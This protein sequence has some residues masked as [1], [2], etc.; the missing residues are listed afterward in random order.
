MAVGEEL[1]MRKVDFLVE[2]VLLGEEKGRGL[3]EVEKVE[4]HDQHVVKRISTRTLSKKDC[5]LRLRP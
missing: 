5:T 4:L 2:D 3:L 1:G